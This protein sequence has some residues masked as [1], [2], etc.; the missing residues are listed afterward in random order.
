DV[1][2][3]GADSAIRANGATAGRGGAGGS[4]YLSLSGILGGPGLV[5]AKGG[6]SDNFAG[7][8][9]GGAIAI[10]YGRGVKPPLA[11]FGATGGGGTP[12]GGAGTVYSFGPSSTF[13][14]L[15]VDN[16]SVVGAATVLP[17][18]GSGTALAGTS[19]RRLA[20]G[21]NLRPYFVGHWIEVLDVEGEY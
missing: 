7:A 14:D 11:R 12:S 17:A 21:P 8:G 10:E 1:V 6:S 13:G 19:G 3:V 18:L 9:G 15:V 2:L 5:E 20:L 4:I 16:R